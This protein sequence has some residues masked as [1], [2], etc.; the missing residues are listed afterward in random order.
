[1]ACFSWASGLDAAVPGGGGDAAGRG[2]GIWGIRTP[3]MW[4]FAITN[5]VWWDRNRPRGYA[6]LRH[7]AAVEPEVAQLHQPVRRAMTLFA[8]ACAVCSRCCTGP[9]WLFLLADALPP[10]AWA[11][12]PNFRSPLVWTCSPVSTYATVSLLFWFVGLLPDL[13]TLRDRAHTRPARSRTASWPWAG[14][15]ARTGACTKPPPFLLAAWPP[16]GAFGAYGGELRLHIAIVPGWQARSS[17]P[18]SCRGHLLPASPWC[19]RWPFRCAPSTGCRA[20]SRP[21]I[22]R[23]PPRS[24][25][26]GIDRGLRLRDRGVLGVVH[27]DVYGRP[28]W[29][30]MTGPYAAVYWLSPMR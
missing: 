17:R 1:M 12:Q 29:H 19:W 26:H 23:T 27:G 22:W 7:P 3:V 20:S 24:C 13:A 16:P 25:G 15:F 21:A 5:F 8:V 9:P 14:R 10:T 4:G 2:V 28:Q 11:V 18:T 30:R 6:H